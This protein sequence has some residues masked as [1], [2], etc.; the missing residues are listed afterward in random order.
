MEIP[1]CYD[2]SNSISLG[3]MENYA[4]SAAVQVSA[5]LGTREHFDSAKMF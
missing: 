1:P 3:L 4:K 2:F 5:L